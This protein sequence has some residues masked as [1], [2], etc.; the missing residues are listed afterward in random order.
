[1]FYYFIIVSNLRH[2]LEALLSYATT[3]A[4]YLRLRTSAKYATRPESLRSHPI[5]ARLLT[6]KQSLAT[7]EDLDFALSDDDGEGTDGGDSS[8]IGS[9]DS[10]SAFDGLGGS[11]EVVAINGS[12]MNNIARK[13]GLDAGE[14]EA[15]LADAQGVWDVEPTPTPKRKIRT[16]DV[17][18]NIAEPVQKKRKTAGKTAPVFDLVEP[19]YEPATPARTRSALSVRESLAMDAYGELVALH[20]AD[21]EDKR[22]RKRSLQFYTSK[23][24]G[25]NARREGARRAAGG[26]DDDIPYRSRERQKAKDKPTPKGARGEDLDDAEPEPVSSLAAGEVGSATAGIDM[27]DEGGDSGYYSLI[28]ATKKAAKAEKQAAYDAT[29][30]AERCAANLVIVVVHAEMKTLTRR[31]AAWATLS[32]QVRP[33]GRRRGRAPDD[34]ACDHEKPWVDAPSHEKR[35]KPTG[36]EAEEVRSGAKETKVAK[37]LLQR[38]RRHSVRGRAFG[39]IQDCQE[40]PALLARDYRHYAF[41]ILLCTP[42]RNIIMLRRCQTAD[43]HAEDHDNTDGSA[44][45]AW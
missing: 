24:D 30:A 20:A 10:G 12:Q 25:A 4:F 27:G 39:H 8:Q 37:G 31:S 35:P 41:C 45:H 2:S 15:L 23:L 11:D 5:F 29:R 9:D 1:M 3:L 7:L 14:L 43:A 33:R 36:E 17:R 6:L 40:R 34:F 32:P 19:E 44:D 38:R 42:I 13:K 26:G 16:D 18:L 22:A 21:A 28:A